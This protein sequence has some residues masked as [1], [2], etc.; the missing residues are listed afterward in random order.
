MSFTSGKFDMSMFSMA[1]AAEQEEDASFT[2]PEAE[3][4]TV[5]SG[6]TV[7]LAKQPIEG[8]VYIDGLTAGASAAAGVY[9][10]SEKTITFAEGDVAVGDQVLVTY[11]TTNAASVVNIANKTSAIGEATL[12]WPVYSSGDDCTESGVKG[13]IVCKIFRCRATQAPGFDTSYKSA[14]TNSVTFSAM[15]AKRSDGRSYAIAYIPAE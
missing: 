4:L 2:A 13:H 11:E 10:I 5:A 3:Y 1:N 6:L 14:A 12:K 9:T 7:T 15:D 8:S